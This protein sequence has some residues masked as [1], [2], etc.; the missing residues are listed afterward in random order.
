MAF[1][2]EQ[3]RSLFLMVGKLGDMLNDRLGELAQQ[4]IVSARSSVVHAPVVPSVAPSTKTASATA[5]GPRE[6]V[7]KPHAVSEVSAAST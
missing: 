7:S 2:A 6:A 3:L 4:N 5:R 1:Q